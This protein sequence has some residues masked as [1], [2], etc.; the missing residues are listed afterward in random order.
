MPTIS[1]IARGIAGLEVPTAGRIEYFD[2][3]TPGFGLRVTAN[4]HRS[5]V[6]L[7]RHKGELRRYTLGP[8]PQLGLADAREVAREILR[9]AAKGEDPAAEKR[10]ERKAETFRDLALRYLDQ[11]AKAKK[12]TWRADN[13][14]VHKDLIPRFGSRKAAE[15]TRRDIRDV[16]KAITDRGSPIQANRTLEI[17]RKLFNWAISEEL[18]ENNPCDHIGKPSA[19]NQRVRVLTPQEIRILWATLDG[20]PPLVAAAYRVL[21]ATAQRS[22]EVLGARHE[23]IGADGWWTIPSC[24]V[25]NKTEHRVWLSEIARRQLAEIEPHAREIVAKIDPKARDA[26]KE[27]IFPSRDGGHLRYLHKTHSRL[28]R[29]SD[30][31]DFKIH[32]LRRTAASHMSAA[33]IS[34]LTIAK[35][36][37]H[38]EREITAVY[39]RY[40]YGPEI[41]HALDAW[42]ARL[43]E[44]LSGNATLGNVTPLRVTA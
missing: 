26:A 25:K 6:C 33:G 9:R 4:G 2:K 30:L 39:D 8:Y 41:R 11:H 42:N 29:A 24:R 1:L 27:W 23:E 44:I 17:V 7:Y 35:V 43:E 18:A 12:R 22:I 36:L 28:C 14:I 10:R 3:N 5:W 32:D 38:K 16:L 40:G 20:R 31:S 37:N 21:L 34:R 15:L 13:N 19:E